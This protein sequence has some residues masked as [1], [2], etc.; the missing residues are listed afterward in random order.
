MASCGLQIASH[1][2]KKKGEC[3]T[4]T[5]CEKDHIHL[6]SSAVHC[7]NGS[8]SLCCCCSPLPAPHLSA[9][10]HTGMGVRINTAREGLEPHTGGFGRSLGPWNASAI[11]VSEHVHALAESASFTESSRCSG[12]PVPVGV[13]EPRPRARLA[14]RLSHKQFRRH[15]VRVQSLASVATQGRS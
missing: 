2:L 15:T 11:R 10:L 9:Q 5:Y 12:V 4:M 6:T 1:H 7:Y 8:I 13:D 14:C 3:R